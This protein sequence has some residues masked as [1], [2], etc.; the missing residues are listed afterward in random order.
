MFVV[1]RPVFSVSLL[2][3]VVCY[4]FIYLC[5]LFDV[6]RCFVVVVNVVVCVWYC[7]LFLLLR[8]SLLWLVL[9]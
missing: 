1:R 7:C 8:V 6:C 9:S 2:V 5:L 4:S 3:V